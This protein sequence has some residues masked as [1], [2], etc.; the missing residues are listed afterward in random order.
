MRCLLLLLL[1]IPLFVQAQNKVEAE[2]RIKVRDVPKP[3][4]EWLQDAFEQT[5]KIRWYEEETSGA[6]SFEAKFFYQYAFYSVEFDTLGVIED[7]EVDRA[8]EALPASHRL[9]I[10]SQLDLWDKVKVRRIQ[11]Q[12]TGEPDDLE[13]AI[14]EDKWVGI[15]TRYEVEI[16][17]E[18]E[19]EDALWEVLFSVEGE[20]LHRR[21]IILRAD[22]NLNF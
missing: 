2:R 20:V 21:K 22:D 3:A 14:D 19:G 7:I 9:A 1:L 10:Q 5:H 12:W 8:W 6:K 13:D 15:T 4:R 18:I 17:A 11:E 16:V